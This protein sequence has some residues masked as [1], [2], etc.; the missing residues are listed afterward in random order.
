LARQ[1][2]NA[3][4]LEFAKGILSDSGYFN[5]NSFSSTLTHTNNQE[6][7]LYSAYSNDK[8]GILV[9][10]TWWENEATGAFAR[11][12]DK[13]NSGKHERH[14]GFMPTPRPA[15]KTGGKRAY[16]A[17]LESGAFINGYIDENK[18]ALAKLFMQFLHTDAQLADITRVSSMPKPFSYEI[19]ADMQDGTGAYSGAGMTTYAKS[20]WQARQSADILYPYAPSPIFRYNATIRGGWRSFTATVDGV[21]EMTP[22][23]TFYLKPGVTV[24]Q[25][26]DG[27]YTYRSN[28]EWGGL[29]TGQNLW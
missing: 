28:T 8:I 5:T 10:G 21:T 29:Y 22:F 1:P 9:D 12:A 14:F 16:A 7:F 20:L 26:F 3:R 27:I 18:K 23:S 19:P 17:V 15:D 6:A 11:M 13:P 25:Y 24:K 4:A 2:G